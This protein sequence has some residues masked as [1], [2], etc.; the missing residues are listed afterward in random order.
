MRLLGL[1]SSYKEGRLIQHAART[2]LESCDAVYVLEGPAG[3][4]LEADVPPTELGP[5]LERVELD[6]GVWP[7]DA[8][9]RNHLL[10]WA[11]GPL[12]C[13]PTWGLWIDADEVLVNGPYLRDW[14]ELLAWQDEESPGAPPN[15]RCPLR[16]IEADGS[17]S[18]SL[19]KLVR[20][21]LIDHY[22]ISIAACVDLDGKLAKG[23]NFHDTI[24][25]YLRLDPDRSEK[26]EQ[27]YLYW[28]PGPAPLDPY[29]VHRSILRHPRRAGLRLNEQEAAQIAK[30][31]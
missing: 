11:R 4:P 6:A 25:R 22:T 9:K 8:E 10:R 24:G 12:P 19:A 16:L 23:G 29:L 31:G 3:P 5:L 21:D 2:A 14:L 1:I 17:V 27:G 7:T 30:Q 20:L 18:V 15:A 28:P 13:E 26:L